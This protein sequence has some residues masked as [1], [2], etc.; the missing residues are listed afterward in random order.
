MGVK[1]PLPLFDIEESLR[2]ADFLGV[3]HVGMEMRFSGSVSLSADD[4][5]DEL[6]FAFEELEEII[7][8]QDTVR[9]SQKE[10]FSLESHCA[11]L[12]ER[13]SPLFIGRRCLKCVTAPF[14][15]KGRHES[16]TLD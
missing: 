6:A 5:A 16:P 3:F 15:Q 12:A 7:F 8:G 9:I 10:G 14:D 13:T 1:C 4:V 11:V 2:P